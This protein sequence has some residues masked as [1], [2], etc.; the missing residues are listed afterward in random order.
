M[1]LRIPLTALL[2]W[3]LLQM[4]LQ[5]RE[6]AQTH[7]QLDTVLK[8]TVQQYRPLSERVTLSTTE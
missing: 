6:F 2:T 7:L 1:L 5:S 4:A 8:P 3:F